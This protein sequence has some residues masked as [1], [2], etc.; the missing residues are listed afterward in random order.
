VPAHQFRFEILP[1]SLI[2][3]LIAWCAVV[4]TYIGF[5]WP[6]MPRPGWWWPQV[7][8]VVIVSMIFLFGITYKHWRRIFDRSPQL[9][10]YADYLRAKQLKGVDIPWKDVRSIR[11]VDR[12]GGATQIGMNT[13]NNLLILHVVSMHTVQLT[14]DGSRVFGLES[15][16]TVELN[17][18]GLGVPAQH[19]MALITSLRPEFTNRAF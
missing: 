7:P 12:I 19:V 15:R 2:M 17:L 3:S 8:A 10:L 6:I 16:S 11:T 13:K 14:L 4:G 18:D 1:I 9:E 5:A